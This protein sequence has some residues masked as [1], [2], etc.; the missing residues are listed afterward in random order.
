M[1]SSLPP[2]AFKPVESL[3]YAGAYF[4][5]VAL[6][7]GPAAEGAVGDGSLSTLH[8]SPW[9]LVWDRED[10]AL[11][12]YRWDGSAWLEQPPSAALPAL[13]APPAAR[14]LSLAFDQAGRPV[15]AWEQAGA[16]Y[17]RQWD[18]LGGQYVTRGPFAGADPVLLNDATVSRV[19]GGSDVVLFHL[20]PDRLRLR[21]R[22]QRE[23]YATAHDLLDLGGAPVALA[24]PAHLDQAVAL[25][26]RYELAL[27][28]EDHTQ[29]YWRSALYDPFVVEAVA[30]SAL[31][32]DGGYV[33]ALI[34]AAH[35]EA[36]AGSA[37]PGDGSY[38]AAVLNAARTEALAGS[39]AP[40]DGQ[41]A[42]A[43][44]RH[45]ATEALTGAS[46]PRD[47]GYSLA[48]LRVEKTE[49]LAGSAQPLD[50]SYQL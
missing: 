14:H 28:R 20:S 32:L 15:V 2:T 6:A 12:L 49:S 37:T 36:L 4:A 1:G 3:K 31:P 47:G 11:R 8:G 35:T 29:L 41:Y 17:V 45:A 33:S 7:P 24:Q 21:W 40:R 30:G 38:T 10:L 46:A 39:S 48:V 13:P 22:V 44:I 27:E 26:W 43:V 19:V 16:V 23:Q 18:P 9:A 34:N 25:P 5:E 42:L 50:G